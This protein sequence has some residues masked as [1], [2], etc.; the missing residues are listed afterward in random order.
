MA[1]SHAPAESIANDFR[2]V[3]AR[4]HTLSLPTWLK[5]G[6][7]MAQF[8][9]L[10]VVSNAEGVSISGVGCELGIGEPTASQLVDALVKQG[11]AEREPDP[12]D[13]RRVLVRATPLGEE[14]VG[15]LRHGRRQYFSGWLAE[16]APEDVDALARGLRALAAA[17]QD[18]LTKE[19]GCKSERRR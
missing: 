4:L 9:A 6:L 16:M 7:T 18:G 12:A 3:N 17:S 2:A 1:E 10:A 13:R 8:K 11:Y 19:T 5:L 15:E 14:L